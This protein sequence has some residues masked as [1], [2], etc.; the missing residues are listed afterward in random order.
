MNKNRILIIMAVVLTAFAGW[1]IW[2]NRSGTIREELRDFAVKDTGSVV[3]IFMANKAGQQ[4]LLE[5]QPDGEWMLNNT[6]WARPDAIETLLST[7]YSVEV[8]SP[9]ARAA[10][11]NIIKSLAANGVKVEVYS[12]K[13]LIKTYYVGGPTQDQLGT[14]MYLENSTVPFITHIPG[15]NGYLTPRYIV[16][17][18]DWLVKNVFRLPEGQLKTLDVIDRQRPGYA[19]RIERESSGDYRILN[20]EGQPVPDIMQDKVIHYLQMYR[21]LN[22]EKKETQISAT[23]LDSVRATTPFRTITLTNQ[24]GN[25]TRIDLW[26]KPITE[27]TVNKGEEEGKPYP[28]DVDRMLGSINGDTTLVNIQYFSFERLFLKPS[29]FQQVNVSR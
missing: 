4:V 1:L 5:K 27:H 25:T 17:P 19:F 10:Y 13:G 21:L 8:R 29:D 28:F 7:L 20:G 22:Y 9:V 11:N 14:Y 18:D 12:S 2:N 16:N 24:S 15:F 26:R 23:L 3:K 6:H